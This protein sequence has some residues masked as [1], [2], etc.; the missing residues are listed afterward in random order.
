[1]QVGVDR[2]RSRVVDAHRKSDRVA[3]RHVPVLPAGIELVLLL[4]EAVDQVARAAS[5]E[6]VAVGH[7]VRGGSTRSWAGRRAR[8]D[9]GVDRKRRIGEVT[10]EWACGRGVAASRGER[11]RGQVDVV[12]LETRVLG[13]ALADLDRVSCSSARDTVHPLPPTIEVVEA[14]VLLIDDDDVLDLR[15]WPGVVREDGGGAGGGRGTQRRSNQYEDGCQMP[16]H[17]NPSAVK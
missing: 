16:E 13:S 12:L 8:R 6:A 15:E 9:E 10:E 14:V 4:I 2:Q 5:R 3:A 7:S 17:R 1:M 11:R